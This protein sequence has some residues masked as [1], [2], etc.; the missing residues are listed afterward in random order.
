MSFLDAVFPPGENGMPWV[1]DGDK[2]RV[3]TNAP[4][5][6]FVLNATPLSLR[7]QLVTYLCCELWLRMQRAHRGSGPACVVSAPIPFY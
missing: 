7:C 3:S 4:S 5:Q 1:V 2:R 6:V